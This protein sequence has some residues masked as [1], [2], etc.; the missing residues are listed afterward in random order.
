[1]AN[2]TRQGNVTRGAEKIM[3]FLHKL[4]QMEENLEKKLQGNS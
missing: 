2:R 4:K 1:M 3:A